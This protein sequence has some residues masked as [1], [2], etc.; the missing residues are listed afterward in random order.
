MQG[1]HP[2]AVRAHASDGFLDRSLGAAPAHH[3]QLALLVS[4]DSGGGFSVFCNAT[5]FRL[6][7]RIASWLICR[8]VG[9]VARA[10]VGEPGQR[11]H[12]AG[13]PG[14]KRGPARPCSGSQ[15]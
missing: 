5:S 12:A 4:E 7:C 9:D 8:V 15:S 10:I 14:T 1:G 2:V 11:V 3:Q 6:R 13:W